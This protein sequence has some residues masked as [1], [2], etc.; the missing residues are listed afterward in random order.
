MVMQLS[1]YTRKLTVIS[2]INTLW[3]KSLNLLLYI[4]KNLKS[5]FVIN[6]LYGQI[7]DTINFSRCLIK[8]T[9]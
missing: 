7:K 8:Y 3:K 4:C 2:K 1:S 6:K 5:L 9:H